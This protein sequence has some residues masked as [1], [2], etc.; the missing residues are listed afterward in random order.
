VSAKQR[1]PFGGRCSH[2]AAPASSIAAAAATVAAA[3]V[4]L[5]DLIE[6]FIE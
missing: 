2:L 1:N 3:C 4:H 6:G 5:D